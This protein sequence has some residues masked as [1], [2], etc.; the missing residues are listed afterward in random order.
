MK[1]LPESV[2][3]Y[4][5]SLMRD[6]MGNAYTNRVQISLCKTA[7]REV[8]QNDLTPRQKQLVLMYYYQ[9]LNNKQIAKL[10]HIDNST[11]SRTLKRARKKIYQYLHIYFDYLRHEKLED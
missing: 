7:L 9:N 4:D 3:E 5:R 10:L 6:L 11:V 2:L 1:R 8:I